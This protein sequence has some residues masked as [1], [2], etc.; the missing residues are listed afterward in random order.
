MTDADIAL[1]LADER[2]RDAAHDALDRRRY[3]SALA[4]YELRLVVR[5]VAALAAGSIALLLIAGLDTRAIVMTAGAALALFILLIAA[6][7]GQ[8][9]RELKAAKQ[10][11]DADMAGGN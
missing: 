5:S 9:R 10:R 7:F 1:M 11:Y 6:S 3:F 4:H 2:D 8:Y